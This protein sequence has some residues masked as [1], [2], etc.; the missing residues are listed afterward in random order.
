MTVA[1]VIVDK[2]EVR[3]YKKRETEGESYDA[4]CFF[5]KNGVDNSF[6]FQHL[7]SALKF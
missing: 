5:L 3:N 7:Q 4:F 1:S 2:V 6:S